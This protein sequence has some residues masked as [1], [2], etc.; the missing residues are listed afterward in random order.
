MKYL[1]FRVY[2]PMSSWGDIAVGETRPSFTHPSKSAIMGLVAG[3]L[4]IRRDEE[5][6]HCLLAEV[7][8]FA[9]LVESAGVPLLDYHTAQVPSGDEQYCTRKDEL[10]GARGDLNTILSTRDYR[11]DGLYTVILWEW[12]QSEWA[13]DRIEK[14]LVRPVFVPYLGRKSCPTALPF[15]A[16]V[17]EA[18]S[19]VDV[20]SKGSFLNIQEFGFKPAGQKTLYWEDCDG[21][22][23][24]YQ[25]IF[26]R[27]DITLSRG[28]WQFDVRRERQA[29]LT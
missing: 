13:L 24:D 16:Q 29:A 14:A 19:L 7:L 27:R 11:G 20:I 9:V 5:Q 21:A 2:G 18:A 3:A 26:E 8:G 17:V 6:T 23:I 12:K 4:G 22:G 28:R 25:H 10:A 1:L 15:Q